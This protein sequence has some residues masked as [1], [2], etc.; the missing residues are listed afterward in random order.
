MLRTQTGHLRDL[1]RMDSMGVHGQNHLCN[2][3][4]FAR[5]YALCMVLG[6]GPCFA[7]GQ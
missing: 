2:G 4:D 1:V 5:C 3:H 7:L 6:Q